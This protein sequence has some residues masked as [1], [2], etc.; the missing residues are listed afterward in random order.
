[1]KAAKTASGFSRTSKGLWLS[2]CVSSGEHSAGGQKGKGLLMQPFAD[3]LASESR[4]AGSPAIARKG[5]YFRLT[6]RLDQAFFQPGAAEA[7]SWG[8]S[9]IHG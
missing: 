9:R 5:R 8:L 6:S 2:G 4:I 1:V 7:C 3:C